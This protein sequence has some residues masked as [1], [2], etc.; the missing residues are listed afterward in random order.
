MFGCNITLSSRLL[1]PSISCAAYEESCLTCFII[2]YSPFAWSPAEQGICT[3]C[4]H[5]QILNNNFPTSLVS[6][7]PHLPRTPQ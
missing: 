7:Y 4:L 5:T 3:I 6:Y 2:S 1:N